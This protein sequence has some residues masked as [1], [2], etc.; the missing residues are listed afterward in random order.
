MEKRSSRE[1]STTS[2]GDLLSLQLEEY[3]AA[4]PYPV[5]LAYLFGSAARGQTTPFS[6][7][8]VA[9]YLDE[10]NSRQRGKLYPLLLLDL[11][12]AVGHQDLD[13]IYLN[14]A[15]PLLAYQVISGQLVA[16]ADGRQQVALETRV[17][18]EY[19]DE[20]ASE[21]SRHC[22]LRARILKGK[23]GERSSEMI[24]ERTILDRLTYIDATLAR[25]KARR[26]LSL[27]EF[28]ADIDRRDATLY[29]LQTCI[30]AMTDIA[31]HVVAA[32]GLGRPKDRG[33]LF[34]MLAQEGIV[35][36]SLAR[37][38]AAAT[39]LRNLLVHGYLDVVLGA[40]YQMIQDDLGDIEAFSFHIAEFLEQRE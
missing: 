25:L 21:Q 30:E 7:I 24:D 19:F 23:M 29:Q 9:V 27:A 17:L 28:L 10:S 3:F 6:D 13:L 20:R 37:R 38:L 33:D 22:L 4:C 39:G 35:E 36:G 26:S 2:I 32:L 12:R 11:Q 8:D 31:N 5:C 40:V 15:P 18:R 14:E 1:G 34:A 16:C